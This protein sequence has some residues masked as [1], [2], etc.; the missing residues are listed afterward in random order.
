MM[1]L[2]CTMAWSE[3]LQLLLV[4]PW[5]ELHCCLPRIICTCMSNKTASAVDYDYGYSQDCTSVN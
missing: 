1:R 3:L 5:L 2:P 4:G